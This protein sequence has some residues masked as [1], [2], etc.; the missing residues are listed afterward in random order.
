MHCL[1]HSQLHLGQDKCPSLRQQATE[2]TS[3][4]S[5]INNSGGLAIGRSGPSGQG[6]YSQSRAGGCVQPRQGRSAGRGQA[7]MNSEYGRCRGYVPN[8][9][10]CAKCIMQPRTAYSPSQIM[11][12]CD[13]QENVLNTCCPSRCI[14]VT[15]DAYASS[16]N[17][18]VVL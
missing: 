17:P 15:Q 1:E 2:F 13:S 10:R 9:I 6:Q 16:Q 3:S 18:I 5:P 7:H 4:R 12:N 14:R 8:G 11:H